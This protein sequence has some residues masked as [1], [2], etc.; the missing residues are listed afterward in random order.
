MGD[1]LYLAR[2]LSRM[3]PTM[4]REEVGLMASDIHGRIEARAVDLV[5]KH[6]PVYMAKHIDP[7]WPT[8]PSDPAIIAFTVQGPSHRTPFMIHEGKLY[9]RD[10]WI[11]AHPPPEET[12]ESA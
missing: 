12:E 1:P 6:D 5:V 3:L 8:P 11:A 4:S 10:E 9:D 2:M 7:P